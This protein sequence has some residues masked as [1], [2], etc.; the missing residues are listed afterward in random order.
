MVYSLDDT[1]AAIASA[2]GGAA[3]GIVRISGPAAAE[4]LAAI[5]RQRPS[6]APWRETPHTLVFQTELELA[7]L[8]LLPAE[9]IFWPNQRSYTGQ[10]AAEIHTLGSPPLAATRARSPLR[11]RRP[12][13]RTG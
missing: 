8:A 12:A 2:H 1:I 6:P 13:R 5:V 9:V 3:R 11:R 10:S 7:G 4:C